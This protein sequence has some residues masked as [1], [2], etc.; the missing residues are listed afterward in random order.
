LLLPRHDP[1]VLERAR[2]ANF[3]AFGARD[4]L[5]PA[6]SRLLTTDLTQCCIAGCGPAGAVLGLLLARAGIDVLVLEKHS[7]FLRDFRGDTIHPSTLDILDELGLAS[8]FLELPHS[9][10]S[11]LTMQ[12]PSDQRISIDLAR[13]APRFPFIA[14]VP[15]WDFL[16][17]ITTEASRY[18]NF[19][20]LRNAEVTGLLTDD[21]AV[22]GVRYRAPEGDRTVRALLT[23]GADG[24]ASL[25][26][27]AAGLPLV[28]TSPPMDVLWFRLSRRPQE[29]GGA[30]LHLSPGRLVAVFNRAS[31]WQIGYVIP[32]GAEA[33]I[34][35]EGLESF[36]RAVAEIVPELADRVSELD[37]W[38]QVKLLTVRADRLER[39]Y[40]PGYLAIGDAAHAMS[41]VAGVGI[42]I[43]IQDAVVAANVLWRPLREGRVARRHLAEV[44]LRRA[45][46]VRLVQRVQTLIQNQIVTPALGAGGSLKLSRSARFLMR[47]SGRRLLA[48]L[49]TY[50]VGRPRVRTPIAPPEAAE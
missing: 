22:T 19:R 5:S 27:A 24:R 16:E 17:F 45:M 38:D 31:F 34:R 36:R 47:G 40:R 9:E 3:G 7:D 8:R 23:V 6:M 25:T 12:L 43:A 2:V 26:R 44:Q 50:G 48:R 11:A 18:P 49:V 32:K 46:P 10:I 21:G 28:E 13:A 33:R 41:P 4:A 42:N 30:M 29:S 14:F 35:A 39:W 1:I 37:D 20:L 15:Q